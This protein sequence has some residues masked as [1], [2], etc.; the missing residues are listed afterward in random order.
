MRVFFNEKIIDFL[1]HLPTVIDDAHHTINYSSCEQLSTAWKQF[2]ESNYLQQLIILDT[3]I[4]AKTPAVLTLNE[5]RLPAF[6]APSFSAFLSLFKYISA[7]GG[8]VK[9]E[10]D[11]WLFI[12]RFGLWDLPKGK[13]DNRDYNNGASKA[14]INAALRE[15]EEETGLKN[16]KIVRQLPTTWHIFGKKDKNFIKQ[17]FWFEMQSVGSQ[18]LIPQTEEGISQ[19]K[20]V[21]HNDI[22]EI[23]SHTYRSLRE[24]L[25]PVL[26]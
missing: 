11:E 2:S 8:V 16:L 10:S 24:F 12:H 20:W 23:L 25:I 9:N 14:I 26:V 5:D 7:A 1:A 6:L 22:R 3:E 15:V 13:V 4:P 18:I 17:T 21:N 19:V